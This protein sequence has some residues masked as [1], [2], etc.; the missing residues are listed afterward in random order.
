VT[1]PVPDAISPQTNRDERST[2]L[3]LRDAIAFGRGTTAWLGARHTQLV[4]SATP[5]DGAPGTSF[6]QSFTTPFV[7]LSQALGPGQIVYAS[8][9]KGVESDV[10]PNV[11]LDSSATPP[12]PRYSNAG[13]ALPAAESRQIEIGTKGAAG[14]AEWSAAAFDIRRPL[15]GDIATA[16]PCGVVQCTRG[17]VGDQRHKGV[18]GSLA[19]RGDAWGVRAGA[20]WLHARVESPNEPTLDGKRP[21]NV[22]A[23]TAR[24]QGDWQL[25]ALPALRLLAAGTYE[26]AREVL[27]DNSA[28]IPSVTRFDLGARYEIKSGAGA[29]WTLRAGIDNVFD[30]RTWRESP[31]QFSHAYLF[32]L[33]PRTLRVSLQAD[34]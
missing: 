8:W 32:P 14:H 12:V 9:G 7:A 22:P 26:S 4:R 20:Q 16:G 29:T 5:T 21:T 11:P 28:Q 13:Q 3:A 6:K 24:L 2:E 10:A 33:E 30:R 31:Y 27:P 34:L 17:L 23:V 15:F 25:P 1:P 19:W 18:E